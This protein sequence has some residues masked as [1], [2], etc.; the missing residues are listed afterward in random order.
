MQQQ[1]NEYSTII[2]SS[3][4][5]HN[6]FNKFFISMISSEGNVCQLNSEFDKYNE[7]IDKNKNK[8]KLLLETYINSKIHQLQAS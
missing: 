8:K 3:P 5:A 1:Q 7:L 6:S 2:S 4:K